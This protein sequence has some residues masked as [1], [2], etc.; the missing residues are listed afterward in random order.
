MDS[1]C[2]R[3]QSSPL[4]SDVGEA[5]GGRSVLCRRPGRRQSFCGLTVSV[6]SPRGP[7]AGEVT[8]QRSVPF[9]TVK[10]LL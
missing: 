2:P 5:T 7:D 8:E 1:L 9:E 3:R 4:G 10:L 6:S